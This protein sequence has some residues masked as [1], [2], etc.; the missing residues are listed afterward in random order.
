V[1]DFDDRRKCADVKVAT[2]VRNEGMNVHDG[3]SPLELIESSSRIQKA[4]LGEEER[5]TSAR[6][7]PLTSA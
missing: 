5:A 6:H 7:E 4:R 1:R 2:T 3:A